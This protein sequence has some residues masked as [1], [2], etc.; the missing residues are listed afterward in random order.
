MGAS[1][2]LITNPSQI[3]SMAILLG[4]RGGQFK[5]S[6]LLRVKGEKYA[7][8]TVFKADRQLLD[9]DKP[10]LAEFFKIAEG[11]MEDVLRGKKELNA[12]L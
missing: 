6:V 10:T 7:Y 12:V 8:E 2:E 1:E 11:A 5:V 4:D 9:P 3:E